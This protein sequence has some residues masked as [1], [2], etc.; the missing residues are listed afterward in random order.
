MPF[1]CQFTVHKMFFLQEKLNNVHS[2]T[3]VHNYSNNHTLVNN[4]IAT[5][6]NG[7]QWDL[8]NVRLGEVSSYGRLKMK[9]LYVAGTTTMCPLMGGVS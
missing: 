7:H 5:A 9:C 2:F 6:I 1:L 4:T 3:N 8:K